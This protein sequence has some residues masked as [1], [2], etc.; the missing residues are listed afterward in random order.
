MGLGETS[1]I[2]QD[3]QVQGRLNALVR[4]SYQGRTYEMIEEIPSTLY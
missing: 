2:L 3:E 1:A 4:R